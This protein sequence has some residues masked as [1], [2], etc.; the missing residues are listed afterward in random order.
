MD[1]AALKEIMA[2]QVKKLYEMGIVDASFVG[3]DSTPVAANTKQ[4]NPKSFTK[5]KFN[6]GKQPK[7]DPDCALGPT[8]P[9]SSTM[10]GGMSSTGVIKAM[11]WWTASPGC[12]SMS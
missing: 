2:T 1:N 4:N 9:P 7:A 5:D 8:R 12:R 11:C 3:L 6:P 10:S